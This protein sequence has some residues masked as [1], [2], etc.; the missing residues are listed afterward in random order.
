MMGANSWTKDVSEGKGIAEPKWIGIVIK[1]GGVART[2]KDSYPRTCADSRMLNQGKSKEGERHWNNVKMSSAQPHGFFPK[3][4]PSLFVSNCHL[5]PRNEVNGK[6]YAIFLH[7]EVV[8][9][10]A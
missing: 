2:V 5:C 8:R 1:K 3:R 6:S 9:I 10:S 7:M 4:P